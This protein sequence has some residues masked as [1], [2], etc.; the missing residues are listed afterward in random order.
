MN[1]SPPRATRRIVFVAAPGTEILDLVGPLQVFARASEIFVRQNP[2]A[3]PIYSVEVV[4]TSSHRSLVANC[5]LRITAHKTFRELR[6]NIDTL[7]VAGGS[8]IENDEVNAEVIRWLKAIAGRIRRIGSVCTGAM[9]LA[10]AGLLDGRRATT[11]WNWCD[12]LIKRAPRAHVDRDPIFVRDKNVYTSAGVTAGM[13]LA[14]AL[15]EEDHGSRLA[16]QVAR[17][18]VLYLRRPGGQSQFSAALSLQ[19]T[20]RK[21]LRELESWVLDNLDKPLTVPVLAQRVAMSPRN[22]ARVFTKEMKTTPAKFVERLRVETARRRLEESQNS[23]ESIASE[24]GFGNVNSM[25]N[26]FQRTLRIAPG[27]YRRHFR[28]VKRRT[29]AEVQEN[30]RAKGVTE[31][32]PHDAISWRAIIWNSVPNSCL[33]RASQGKPFSRWAHLSTFPSLSQ[34]F[35]PWA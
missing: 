24:C 13:D 27:Q 4:T 10:R 9:L 20:D 18:L 34:S 7:L 23:M 28:H 25:R 33:H 29:K 2:S 12:I 26:V 22:F 17:N 32:V 3:A 31:K 15:V 6:G 19:L 30:V 21:P 35:S 5:G 16:L 14:L 11:H 8:A 1:Q